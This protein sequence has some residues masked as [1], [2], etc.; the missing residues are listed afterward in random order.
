M[1]VKEILMIILR[2]SS[3]RKSLVLG[4]IFKTLINNLIGLL[5][6]IIVV[7]AIMKVDISIAI[8]LEFKI[9]WEMLL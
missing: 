1:V 7:K 2:S 5:F 4:M 9:L 3:I 6:K 8:S